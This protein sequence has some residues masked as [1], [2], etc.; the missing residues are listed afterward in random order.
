M[1]AADRLS[2][3]RR[4]DL[5][6]DLRIVDLDLDAHCRRRTPQR[7]RPS[8]SPSHSSSTVATEIDRKSF[9]QRL[10][11][12]ICRQG[13]VT[14]MVSLTVRAGYCYWEQSM[15]CC[16]RSCSPGHQSRCRVAVAQFSVTAMV[17]P[18]SGG[19]W[20]WQRALLSSFAVT[21]ITV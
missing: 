16:R 2:V 10:G 11:D 12:S 6:Y 13:T 17:L 19:A 4:P 8:R 18:Q 3:K 7:H 15:S 5:P 21:S 9:L 20:I 14:V 1:E